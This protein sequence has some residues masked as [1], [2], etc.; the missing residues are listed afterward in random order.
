M[1]N[2]SDTTEVSVKPED[3]KGGPSLTFWR[4]QLEAYDNAAKS[5]RKDI[6]DAFEEYLNGKR[7]SKAERV[8]FPLFWS[9]VRTIQPALYSRTPV[10]VTEKTFKEM[11]DNVARLA[12]VMLER[13]GKYAVKTSGFDRTMNLAVTH[14]IMAE[15]VTNRVL[16]ESDIDEKVTRKEYQKVSAPIEG[17]D[18]HLMTNTRYYDDAGQEYAGEII[19]DQS[20]AYTEETEYDIR[21]LQCTT[22][23]AHYKDYRHTANARHDDELDWMSFDT[24][25]QREEVRE[26]FGDVA[27]ELTYTPMGTG[28]EKESKEEE[29]KGLPTH[30]ATIT[31]IWNKPKREVY[32]LC[33]GYSKWLKHKNNPEGKDPLK[34]RRFFPCPAFMLGTYGADSMFTAPAYVQLK[35]FIDQVHGAFDRLRRLILGLRK[36]GAFDASKDGL[37]VLNS[38]TD[39][40]VFVSING[41]EEMLGPN[42]SL[43]RLIHFFPTDKIAQ[44]VNELK[45]AIMEF[46]QKVYDLWG[47]PDIYRGIT[48]PNETLGAQQLK[49]KHMSVRF[50][51][52]Q[53]EVQR[54]ARDTIE[55]MCDLYL[56]K[57][58]ESK[59]AEIMGI[60]FMD[61]VREQPYF[62]QALALLKSD[63]ERCLRIDIETDSTITQNMNADIEQKN[64]LA[65]TLFEGIGALRDIDPVYLP[66]AIKAVELGVKSLQ[67]GKLVEQEFEEVVD[68]TL[69]R[70]AQPQQPPPDPALIKVQAQM[71]LEQQKAQTQAQLAQQK[72]QQEIQLKWITAQADMQIEQFMAQNKL[73]LEERKAAQGLQLEQLDAQHQQELAQLEGTLRILQEK[74]KADIELR[75]ADARIENDNTMAQ[76]KA[77][78]AGQP[79]ESGGKGGL[80]IGDQITVNRL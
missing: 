60:Q 69:Q 36:V 77:K 75:K 53:R 58:P 28:R 66:A 78:A 19:E 24:Q 31:Q 59:L 26:A 9:C 43:D 62:A 25:M 42:G 46:E 74:L 32:Y 47:I 2:L 33:K 38:I 49:G 5:W 55:I 72:A 18:G 11:R 70:A 4:A 6:D 56:E 22:E 76:A 68:A 29:L 17:P 54:L 79:K 80:H 13:L 3:D 45:T 48:D 34:L 10:I 27:D 61:P 37:D 14:F 21:H 20:G 7:D 16:F 64:Y 73:Y 39:E 35:D 23:V 67:Q 50:S 8:Y 15:K 41:L 1:E 57:C 52:L 40:A 44:G 63:T 65:K 71:Q 51:V 12:A 30:Y